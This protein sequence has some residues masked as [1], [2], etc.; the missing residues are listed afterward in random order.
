MALAAKDNGGTCTF[1]YCGCWSDYNTACLKTSVPVVSGG[2]YS[3]TVSNTCAEPLGHGCTQDL[4][5]IEFNSC[6]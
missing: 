4:N 6:G 5:K 3:F 1:P 2:S